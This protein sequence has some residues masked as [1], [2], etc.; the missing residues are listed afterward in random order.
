MK[1]T[2]SIPG[3]HAIELYD[4]LNRS[5]LIKPILVAHEIGAEF[6]AYAVSLTTDSIGCTVLVTSAGTTHTT[7]GIGEANLNRFPLGERVRFIRW[8]EKRHLLD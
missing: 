2:F 5:R 7:S 3:V 6:V 1:Y 4:A 8:A